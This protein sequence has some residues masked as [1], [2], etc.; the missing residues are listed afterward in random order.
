M[1]SLDETL[2]ECILFQIQAHKILGTI[3]KPSTTFIS[4]DPALEELIIRNV[5]RIIDRIEK[6]HDVYCKGMNHHHLRNHLDD[7]H[8][9]ERCLKPLIAREA[10]KHRLYKRVRLGQGVWYNWP[11]SMHK[12]KT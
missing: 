9:I 6:Q 2:Q 10:A 4:V 5:G 8:I 7:L 11:I 1:S 3:Y 12:G